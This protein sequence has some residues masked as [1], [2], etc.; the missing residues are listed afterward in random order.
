VTYPRSDPP[1][2]D[3]PPAGRGRGSEPPPPSPVPGRGHPLPETALRKFRDSWVLKAAAILAFLSYGGLITLLLA[4][5][6]PFSVAG[7]VAVMSLA[8]W[9][10][11]FWWYPV[12]ERTL[13]RLGENPRRQAVASAV[14]V[15]AVACVLIV[16]V[17][18]AIIVVHAAR[19]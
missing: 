15:V 4:G 1:P 6:L 8:S 17:L 18:M 2:A 12:F 9:F 16:H 14:E 3:L 7:V 5:R 13:Q 19:S 10:F 11:L